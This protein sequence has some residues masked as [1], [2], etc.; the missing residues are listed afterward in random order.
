MNNFIDMFYDCAIYI[1]D[2]K[3]LNICYVSSLFKNYFPDVSEGVCAS[4]VLPSALL[5][6]DPIGETRYL[7][8]RFSDGS[9]N[10]LEANSAKVS[11]DGK[12]MLAVRIFVGRDKLHMS[13]D[14][15]VLDTLCKTFLAIYVL[16]T[17]NKTLHCVMQSKEDENYIC[18]FESQSYSKVI[19]DFAE[20]Y[21]HP[22]DKARYLKELDI[23]YILKAL[24]KNDKIT[25]EYRRNIGGEFRQVS[26]DIS[27]Y[28]PDRTTVVIAV[29]DINEKHKKRLENQKVNMLLAAAV[30]N[31][32]V[33]AAYINLTRNSFERITL[34]NLAQYSGEKKYSSF[35]ESVENM[36]Q[37]VFPDDRDRYIKTFCRK[38]LLD[39]FSKGES[40]V[41]L[42]YRSNS[43]KGYRWVSTTAVNLTD[44]SDEDITEITLTQVI[45]NRKRNEI[46]NAENHA[47]MA[48]LSRKYVG[49][50]FVNLSE[51]SI[52]PLKVRGG[53]EDFVQNNMPTKS[54]GEVILEYAKAYIADSYRNQVINTL[55]AKLLLKRF[56]SGEDEIDLVYKYKDGSWMEMSIVKSDSFSTDMPYI[57]LGIRCIDEQMVE[58]IDEMA[59]QIAVSRTYSAALSV[60]A[61]LS[62]FHCIH[63]DKK[64][65]SIPKRGEFSILD[66][67]IKHVT[68]K[69]NYEKII[70]IIKQ[71]AFDSE[72]I[73]DDVEIMSY[74]G[75]LHSFNMVCTNITVFGERNIIILVKNIDAE[76]SRMRALSDALAFSSNANM[77]KNE[78]LKSAADKLSEP[79][80]SI[81]GLSSLALASIGDDQ[82]VTDYLCRISSLSGESEKLLS[83]SLDMS[84]LESANVSVDSKPFV[85]E[86]LFSE[87]IEIVST[88]LEQKSQLLE[89]TPSNIVHEYLD[90]DLTRYVQIITTTILRASDCT[91]PGKK[92]KFRVEELQDFVVL[93]GYSK[94]R[95]IYEGSEDTIKNIFDNFGKEDLSMEIVKNVLGLIGGEMIISKDSLILEFTTKLQDV[96]LLSG[97]DLEGKYVLIVDNNKAECESLSVMLQALGV[98][99][100]YI[101]DPKEIASEI[102]EFK[103]NGFEYAA[104]IID[105]FLDDAYETAEFISDI[106]NGSV[107][108]VLLGSKGIS[109]LSGSNVYTLYKPVFN[110]G[111]KKVMLDIISA[112]NQETGGDI[113]SVFKDVKVLFAE[114]N[115]LNLSNAFELF[116]IM[117]V[118]ITPAHNGEEA[119]ELFNGKDKFDIVFLDETMPKLSGARTAEKIRKADSHIPIIAVDNNV[120]SKSTE[121]KDF[122]DEHISKP[123]N[124]MK[125]YGILK[126]YVK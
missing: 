122:A 71:C 88:R 35:D 52:R 32:Y 116:E 40:T 22:Q 61:D 96:E 91:D 87:V 1:A 89:I 15:V 41:Y 49:A 85:F 25:R 90:G 18:D 123:L 11:L 121:S 84:K 67:E 9:V 13:N 21:I 3:T 76:K 80:V 19:N 65:F 29:E 56:I 20:N 98:D 117:G 46:K 119:L 12:N 50:Y 36:A 105:T 111:L 110:T 100:T 8:Y 55:D 17:Q 27:G 92:I 114:D 43:E 83:E 38:N 48:A 60:S 104:V 95:F 24:S 66:E 6:S 112:Q 109:K 113:G 47:T 118:N 4:D 44:I 30:S 103:H 10:S 75:H 39:R 57:V 120:F 28:D 126:K 97:A 26:Y 63:F 102:F 69:T 73:S 94:Y 23:N 106:T 5:P 45:D 54:F 99:S 125:L 81:N 93:E 77:T 72:I 7:K 58:N 86:E 124:V 78:F 37:S 70:S 33:F 34:A 82:K 64:Y 68:D 53:Y 31:K 115:L 74:R 108:I 62:S 2:E 107:A 59:S 42:E 101:Y 16:D 14:A 79:I 51:E